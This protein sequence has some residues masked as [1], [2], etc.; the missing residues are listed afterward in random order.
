MSNISD[1]SYK[2]TQSYL[3]NTNNSI[4]DLSQGKRSGTLAKSE[5]EW[6]DAPLSE[7]NE[8]T[9]GDNPSPLKTVF[10]SEIKGEWLDGANT[11]SHQMNA[12]S[13]D[14]NILKETNTV[15]LRTK[16]GVELT[17]ETIEPQSIAADTIPK[18]NRMQDAESRYAYKNIDVG[19][20][21][22]FK[23]EKGEA[24]LSVDTNIKE[25]AID[26][27]L[28]SS[29]NTVY[30]LAKGIELSGS[31]SKDAET[32]ERGVGASYN[33]AEMAGDHALNA[34]GN[35]LIKDALADQTHSF[36]SNVT[37]D[38]L[39]MHY[40]LE[41]TTQK[42]LDA[43]IQNSQ[44]QTTV[45]V[46]TSIL[47][48]DL[49]LGLEQQELQNMTTHYNDNG[50]AIAGLSKT[51]NQALNLAWSPT[52]R[53]KLAF[54]HS[55]E[56]ISSSDLPGE[57]QTSESNMLSAKYDINK[58]WSANAAYTYEP[59]V[60]GTTEGKISYSQKDDLGDGQTQIVLGLNSENH[61]DNQEF[62]NQRYTLGYSATQIKGHGISL[63]SNIAY[64]TYNN[65]LAPS[66]WDSSL[67]VYGDGAD[68]IPIELV[69][70][71]GVNKKVSVDLKYFGNF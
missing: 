16:V 26:K 17:Q 48:G 19:I 50:D 61:F 68:A 7:S 58:S 11:S 64:Q 18:V 57:L 53:I 66:T 49:T 28:A 8:S 9:E 29:I 13:I 22:D 23:D 52:E 60:K 14:F 36:T 21:A 47:D 30:S 5:I 40:G 3:N 1:S 32:L 41:K 62:N 12:K 31:F 67:R 27:S 2:F 44:L 35:F 54:D 69:L 65:A 51:Q 56:A 15:N 10:T 6:T 55:R 45:G 25:N 20:G 34:N 38:N 4:T 42:Q 63:D 70:N 24:Y 39:N 33:N 43:G 37:F 46:N 71:R 59:H